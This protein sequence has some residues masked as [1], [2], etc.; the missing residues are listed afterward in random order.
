LPA[1]VF[2][3]AQ[4]I[5]AGLFIYGKVNVFLMAIS[6]VIRI[7]RYYPDIRLWNEAAFE[8][9]HEPESIA[10]AMSCALDS[11]SPEASENP[12]KKGMLL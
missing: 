11:G 6:V 1:I 12:P 8:P 9:Q 10:S 7:E 4:L 2:F 5:S 3:P